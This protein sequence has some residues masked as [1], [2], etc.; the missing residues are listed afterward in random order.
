MSVIRCLG[1]LAPH[2]RSTVPASTIGLR[3]SFATAEEDKTVLEKAKEKV[4]EYVKKAGQVFEE[5]GAIGKQFTP[6]GHAGG[7]AQKTAESTGS[8]SLDADKGSVGHAFTTDGPIGGKVQ[9]AAEKV[10]N[11]GKKIEGEGAVG[12]V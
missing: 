2:L 5:D 10:K 11:K 6:E 8:E 9:E 7:T 12:K 3:R 1:N 4:G